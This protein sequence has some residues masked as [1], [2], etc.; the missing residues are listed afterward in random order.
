[1]G[2]AMGPQG[3]AVAFLSVLA[4]APFRH[5]FYQALRRLE[6]V[7]ANKPRWGTA[8]RPIDEPIRFGQEPDLTFAPA[9]LAALEAGTDARPPRLQ[10]RLFG[11]LGPNGPLPIH[12]TEYARDRLRH[13][14]DPTLV[15][16]LDVFHHRFIALF[17]RAWAQ[18][19]AHVHRDRPAEDGFAAYMGAFIGAAPATFRHRDAVPDEGKWFHVAALMP[20]A[21]NAEGLREILQQF[22]RTAVR[23]E[24]FVGHWMRLG[25]GERTQL[26]LHGT[27]L[28]SGAVA[29][30][31]I[32]D[33][34]NKFR[35]HLGPLSLAQYE[36]F[37]PGGRPLSQLVDWVRMYVGF[38]LDWDVRLRLRSAEVPPPRLGSGVRLG[39]TTW[40]GT[41]RTDADAD[42][43]CI[44]AESRRIRARDEGPLTERVG[45]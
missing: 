31:R 12:L 34:Q 9:S 7:Y 25:A 36:S 16:F 11:L 42:D 41:R 26:G 39:W 13:A 1:M 21:R 33:R 43:L 6:C 29:G 32:W 30:S 45:P 20:Q 2:A 18:T 40:L 24:E 35:V 17:Y 38:E 22:F 10:V 44:D 14:G 28:G 4:D 37:L 15:R 8:P 19:Q 3:D 23:I 5:D 27:T